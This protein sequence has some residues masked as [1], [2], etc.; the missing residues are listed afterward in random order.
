MSPLFIY[1]GA[2]LNYVAVKAAP[3]A[4][5]GQTL[6]FLC[7]PARKAMRERERGRGEEKGGGMD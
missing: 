2:V 5:C 3:E 4:S 6:H 7:P 1:K